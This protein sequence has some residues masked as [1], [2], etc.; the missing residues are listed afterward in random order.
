MSELQFLSIDIDYW[1]DPQ[2]ASKNIDKVLRFVNRRKIPAHVVMNHQQML[3]FVDESKARTVIN[4][5]QHSDIHSKD[6]DY[7]D[8]GSWLSY[9]KWRKHGKYIWA[10]NY[11]KT[12]YGNCNWRH[13]N[14]DGD[15]DWAEAK[16]D[17]FNPKTFDIKEL[18][19]QNVSDVCICLSP[20]YT[21]KDVY[22]EL[23]SKLMALPYLKGRL[24]ENFG[25]PCVP[26]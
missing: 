17:F 14:W 12:E 18:L 5:D 10:R 13:F 6:T 4:L 26:S 7:L 2:I 3:R 25:R 1:H 11:Q 23:Y 20:G 19:T 16:S 8:C 21:P 15:L 22:T 9:V 24:N